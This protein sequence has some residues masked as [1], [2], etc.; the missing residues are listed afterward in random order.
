MKQ[1]VAAPW[2]ALL[3]FAAGFAQQAAA[4]EL[5]GLYRGQMN[6]VDARL[7]LSEA[8][9]AV[10]G[11][12]RLDNGY[13]V[14]LIGQRQADAIRGA[15]ASA[16]GAATFLL[17]RDGDG[18]KLLLEETAP[19]TG[20]TIVLHLAFRAEAG[21][22]DSE[23][24]T[25]ADRDLR[26]A[27]VWH[28]EALRHAGDM[29]LRV[30]VVLELRGDGSY[31]LTDDAADRMSTDGGQDGSWQVAEGRLRLLPAGSTQ[32]KALGFY[33]LRG[34]EL[35]LIDAEGHAQNWRRP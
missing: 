26:L 15:A 16:A 35:L 2:L 19:L 28:G 31:R 7:A 32:W 4:A 13:V 34:G 14:K 29:V 23:P 1:A 21:P 5:S 11:E 18:V 27:G 30:A 10:N 20:Q 17:T 9:S 8:G 24:A 22:A 12:I 33:Q 25:D 6:G 3:L